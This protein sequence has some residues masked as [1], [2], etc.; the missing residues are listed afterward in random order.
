MK[1]KFGIKLHCYVYRNLWKLHLL[2]D[3]H[4]VKCDVCV[5][6][7]YLS[8]LLSSFLSSKSNCLLEFPELLCIPFLSGKNTKSKAWNPFFLLHKGSHIHV[9]QNQ[10]TQTQT[11]RMGYTNDT[12]RK[13]D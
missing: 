3:S 6:F 1:F 9:R 8:W 10:L 5:V 12:M 11:S 4:R 7:F 2:R 13:E